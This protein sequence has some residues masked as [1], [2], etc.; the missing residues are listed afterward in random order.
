MRKFFSELQ[1]MSKSIG[2]KLIAELQKNNY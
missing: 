1:K 2:T